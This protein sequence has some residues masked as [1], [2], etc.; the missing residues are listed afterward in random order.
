MR[1]KGL[2]GMAQSDHCGGE[3]GSTVSRRRFLGVAAAF[4]GGSYVRSIPLA[5]GAPL[6]A[7][8]DGN[9]RSR[10]VRIRNP[11]VVDGPHVHGCVLSEMLRETLAVLTGTHS[12]AQ[13]WRR[14]LRP[15]DVVGLK[16]NSSGQG[17]IATSVPM[18]KAL[19][20][21]LVS[22]GWGV[23]QIVCIEAPPGLESELGT[24]PPVRG[25]RHTPVDFG[26]GSDQFAAVLDQITA[27]INVPYLKTHNIAGLTCGLKNLSHGLIKHP[28]RYHENGCTPYIADIV[29]LPAIRRK[30]RLCL[31]DALRVV[32]DRGPEPTIETIADAGTL[33]ASADPVAADAVGLALLNDIRQ[34]RNLEA[35]SSS[36]ADVGYLAAA[37]SNGL[38]VLSLD[39]IELIGLPGGGGG[40]EQ[41]TS[42]L[43]PAP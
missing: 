7:S 30:L 28:A 1:P 24:R 26:S 3:F 38:G 23:D 27:L 37:C 31:V 22:A 4:A 39:Q 15:D 20:G 2:H 40:I 32:F 35:V 34:Q 17:I 11:H 10:V 12:T 13:A 5:N 33:I 41:G 21:S 29:A 18:A 25:Y 42:P 8:H 36:A 9:Q 16:F 19:I 6:D 14:L 43:P